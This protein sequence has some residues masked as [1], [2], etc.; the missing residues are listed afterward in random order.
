VEWE[1]LIIPDARIF[2]ALIEEAKLL[3]PSLREER[4]RC[5]SFNA[6]TKATVIDVG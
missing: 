4:D 1:N 3:I 6:A 5:R 2:L